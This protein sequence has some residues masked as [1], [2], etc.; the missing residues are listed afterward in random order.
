MS[1]ELVDH[2]VADL[3][4]VDTPRPFVVG[5]LAILALMIAASLAW[6][7]LGNRFIDSDPTLTSFSWIKLLP[8]AL[9][10]IGFGCLARDLS[11]PGRRPGR[12]MWV[13]I[14][15]AVLGV[16]G[17]VVAGW[18]DD[19]RA[20][21]WLPVGTKCVRWI[22][23]L[24]IPGLILLF[25]FARRRAVTRPATAGACLGAAS[26]VIGAVVYGMSCSIDH[27]LF[28]GVW[29][30]AGI[31]IVTVLGGVIGARLLRW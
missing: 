25:G 21:L 15:A 5:R 29:Y 8:F 22:V 10:V 23:L 30:V 13:L 7:F 14:V 11:I 18:F 9:G 26:G 16:I 17:F 4:P 19:G 27:L 2:L 24:S 28:V 20:S 12:A 3:R 1:K 31:F 6:L